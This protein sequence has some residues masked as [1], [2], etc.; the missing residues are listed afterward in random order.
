M[1]AANG[2][3]ITFAQFKGRKRGIKLLTPPI[4]PPVC[5]ENLIRVDV[6]MESPKLAE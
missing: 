4:L 6:M 5:T 3:S 1:A 2:L